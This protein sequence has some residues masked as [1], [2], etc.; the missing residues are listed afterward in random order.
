MELDLLELEIYKIEMSHTYQV[1]WTSERLMNNM[2][3][4]EIKFIF[5]AP[6]GIFSMHPL[7][8]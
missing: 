3:V 2:R 1:F 6:T 4:F 7:D 8:M 5:G